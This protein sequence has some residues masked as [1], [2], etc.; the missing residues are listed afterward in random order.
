[1]TQQLYLSPALKTAQKCSTAPPG[2]E[3]VTQEMYLYIV[4][5]TA[6][7]HGATH[8]ARRMTQQVYL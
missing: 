4:L 1:M 2:L 7:K 3:T 8:Q 5:K 6:Q